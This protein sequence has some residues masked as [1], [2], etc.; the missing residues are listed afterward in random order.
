MQPA[1]R[2]PHDLMSVSKHHSIRHVR[3]AGICQLAVEAP[4]QGHSRFDLSP[5]SYTTSRS[6]CWVI[7]MFIQLALASVRSQAAQLQQRGWLACQLRCGISTVYTNFHHTC[8]DIP[9]HT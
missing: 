6:A 1:N 9:V 5:G 3:V 4:P 7:E 2:A 8:C